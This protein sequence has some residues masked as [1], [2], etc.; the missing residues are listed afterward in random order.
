MHNPSQKRFDK[1]RQSKR[2][3]PTM[4]VVPPNVE[5]EPDSAHRELP[6][7]VRADSGEIICNISIHNEDL[8]SQTLIYVNVSFSEPDLIDNCLVMHSLQNRLF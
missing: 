4:K 8:F 1:E 2:S 3:K 5:I 7:K 6:Y